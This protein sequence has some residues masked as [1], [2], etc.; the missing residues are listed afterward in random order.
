MIKRAKGRIGKKEGCCNGSRPMRV[1]SGL[2][3]PLTQCVRAATGNLSDMVVCEV[4]DLPRPQLL[5]AALLHLIAEVRPGAAPR[6]QSSV[7]WRWGESQATPSFTLRSFTSSH[8]LLHSAQLHGTRQA[9]PSFTLY[10]FT[11]HVKPHPHLLC[12]ASR[13][14]SSHTLIY[15]AQLHST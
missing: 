1:V 9:T 8:T 15:S 11:A 12:T 10:S 3:H 5:V 13:H 14:T 4:V 2:P 7:V 6:V